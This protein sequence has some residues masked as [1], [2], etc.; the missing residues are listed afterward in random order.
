MRANKA[1]NKSRRK[2][3]G[4]SNGQNYF[5]APMSQKKI[6][7]SIIYRTQPLKRDNRQFS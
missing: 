3:N 6:D 1:A 4:P 5:S 7:K 2:P